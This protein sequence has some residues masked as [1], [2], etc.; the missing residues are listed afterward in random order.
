MNNEDERQD[1]LAGSSI[2]TTHEE[3]AL[4]RSNKRIMLILWPFVN[5]RRSDAPQHAAAH[6]IKPLE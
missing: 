3:A 4:R 1:R 6:H 2:T 5:I